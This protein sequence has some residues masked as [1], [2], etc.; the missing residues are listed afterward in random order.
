MWIERSFVADELANGTLETALDGW[1]ITYPP[2]YL[3]YPNR[4]VSPL[5]KALVDTLRV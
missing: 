3:Y 4:N 5:L 2:Y 1:A